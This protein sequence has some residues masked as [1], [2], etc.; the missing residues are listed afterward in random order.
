MT[1]LIAGLDAAQCKKA[2]LALQQHEARRDSLEAIQKR[3]KEWC[4]RT[5]GI[6]ERLAAA[7][8]PKQ[9][10]K[11]LTPDAVKAYDSRTL[12]IRLVLLRMA[13]RAYTLEHG[14]PP[15]QAA[16][17]VPTYLQRLPLDPATGKP[18]ELK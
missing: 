2:L 13:A 9:G 18:L 7:A 4:L 10:L 14:T 1:N 11:F 16:D 5:F 8:R 15:A 3:E 6:L 17:L 12:E